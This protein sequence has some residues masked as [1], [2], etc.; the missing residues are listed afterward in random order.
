MRGA[1]V[2]LLATSGRHTC[3]AVIIYTGKDDD[4]FCEENS[5]G[6]GLQQP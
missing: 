1:I 3:N 6:G 5:N 4:V 2:F